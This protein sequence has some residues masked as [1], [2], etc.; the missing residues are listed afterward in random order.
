MKLSHYLTIAVGI[1]L[2]V[3]FVANVSSAATILFPSGGGTGSSTL[4]GI[5]LGNGASPV[6]S[7]SIGTNLTLVG[8]TLNASGSG[9]SSFAYPFPSNATSTALTFSGGFSTTYASTTGLSGT[10][11]CL[12][13]DCRTAWPSAGG[14]SY[15]FDLAGNATSTLTQFNGGLTAFAS[16]TI[17]NG[18]ATGG[19][20]ISGNASTSL[21][22]YIGTTL[23]IGTTTGAST[24]NISAATAPTMTLTGNSSTVATTFALADAN[25]SSNSFTGIINPSGTSNANATTQP[26]TAIFFSGNGATNG[27]RFIS[28]A[29]NAPIDFYTGGVV[30]GGNFAMKILG[31]NQ[32]VGIGSSTPGTRLGVNGDAVIAGIVTS[33][34]FLATS[35]LTASTFPYASTTALTISDT[36]STTNL[37]VSS[38]G[39]VGT[40]CAQFDAAG[41]LSANASACGSGG[42]S[43]SYPFTALTTFGTS[44]AATSSSIYTAG[45]YFASSTTAASQLPYASTTALSATTI[46][47]A[48]FIDTSFS[49]NNCIGE[50]SGVIGQATNCV[51]SLASAG[52]SLTI[53][54]PTGNVDAS[55]NLGHSNIFTVLQSFNGG[56][57]STG[58]I[59]AATASSTGLIVSGV[60]NALHLASADGTVS[61]Y[62][63]SNPCTNQVALSISA[64]GV[65]SCTSIT[66]A[67]ITNS[68]IDLTAKVTGVLPIANGGTNASS[69][70]TSGNAI[71][72]D[73]TRLATALTTASVTTPFASSTVISATGA[74]YS[75]DRQNA[76]TGPL[77]PTHS[78][79]L[80]TG[81]TTGWT[82]TTSAP[83]IPEAVAPFAGTLKQVRCHTDQSFVGVEIQING[84]DIAPKYF[85]SSTTVGLIVATGSNTFVAG[86]RISAKFGTTT[87]SNTLS[88]SC[89]LDATQS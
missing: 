26:L 81:T 57:S 38:A 32:F 7:L 54:S 29:A 60:R 33:Q 68:T 83:Y 1:I 44:T 31:T 75:L 11:L 40:R 78:L 37:I 3:F 73:G 51:S 62:G 42:S 36:A 22:Q 8:T 10:F 64:V 18:T 2:G 17:G 6:Q 89:T 58:E 5:L 19:L 72:W 74:I 56:A 50:S 79:V 25:T 28:R 55:L 34:Y 43:F 30:N 86:D 13:T 87:S 27:L 41:T 76:W 69:F 85:I 66:N 49:G 80:Q 48:N 61:G 24:V 70:T 67:M 59:S 47:A 53:S 84:S 14:G 12:S 16:S 77:S 52:G 46:Y 88:V 9:G 82:A 45:V 65:I 35:T 23:F 15:P 71:Y 20:T 63:G 4:T 39:G 21:S